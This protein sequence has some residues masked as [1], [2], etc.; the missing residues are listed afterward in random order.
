M[1]QEQDQLIIIEKLRSQ[2]IAAGMV[3][4]WTSER[5]IRLSQTLDQYIAHFLNNKKTKP[6]NSNKSTQISIVK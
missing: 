1:E 6:E 3:E 5:T 2:M 4:G